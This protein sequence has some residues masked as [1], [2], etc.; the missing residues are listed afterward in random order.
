MVSAPAPASAAATASATPRAVDAAGSPWRRG[1]LG[2]PVA[3]GRRTGESALAGDGSWW[4]RVGVLAGR[5]GHGPIVV[6]G[7][8]TGPPAREASPAGRRRP[9]PADLRGPSPRS[10]ARDSTVDSRA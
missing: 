4:A 7:D 5:V 6:A 2:D 3:V 10:D 1:R 9:S 8:A